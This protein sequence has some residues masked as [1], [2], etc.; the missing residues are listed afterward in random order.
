MS[1]AIFDSHAHFDD[2][3]W[4]PATLIADLGRV[5]G[6][7]G[8]VSA[9]FGPERFA[10][11]RAVCRAVREVRRAVGLHPWWL[12]A[13]DET[14][15]VAGWHA[16]LAELDGADADTIV[17]IGELGVDKNRKHLMAADEQVRWMTIALHQAQLR[18][19][20]IV[21]HIVGWHGHALDALRAVSPQWRGVVHRF[22]GSPALI[23]RYIDLGLHVA[24]ALEPRLE[25]HKRLLLARAVPADRLLLETDWPFLD[26]DYPQAMQEL[27]LMAAQIADA[28]GEDL[29]S[30]IATN[31][32]NCRQVY[33]LGLVNE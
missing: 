23:P 27:R 19:L 9:G 25:V 7:A 17:A 11:S 18:N 33:G 2:S 13:H 22:S 20:P 1:P 28:R 31:N 12:A 14:Q 32:A 30:L 21:L 15:R 8:A 26:L 4:P 6:L 29:Q 3:Q 24:L 16:V 10:A 5:Q